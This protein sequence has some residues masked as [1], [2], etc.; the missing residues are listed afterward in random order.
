MNTGGADGAMIMLRLRAWG[1]IDDQM[2]VLFRFR[3]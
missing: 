1:Q 3:Q 2:G